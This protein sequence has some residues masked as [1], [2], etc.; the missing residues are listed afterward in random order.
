ML[1]LSREVGKS[2][3]IRDQSTQ[4]IVTVEQIAGYKVY[5]TIVNPNNDVVS[6]WV[7]I[8]DIVKVGSVEVKISEFCGNKVKLAFTGP[9]STKIYRE[10]LQKKIDEE[11]EFSNGIW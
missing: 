10:E 3:V 9:N 8:N 5:L 6:T 2:I 11:S 1:V 4:R 7:S